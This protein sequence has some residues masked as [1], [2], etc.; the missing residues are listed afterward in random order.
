MSHAISPVTDADFE[1]RA[2]RADRPVLVDFWAS[3]CAPCRMIGPIVEE[4]AA[5]MDGR[6]LVLEMDIDANPGTPNRLG[7]RSIPTLIVFKDGQPADRI[8]GYRAGLKADLR[9]RLLALLAPS[10]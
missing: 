5:E 9:E 1:S 2:L 8:V 6:V 7:V 4:I 3:W 10:R